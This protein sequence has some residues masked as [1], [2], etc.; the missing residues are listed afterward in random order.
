MKSIFSILCLIYASIVLGQERM[1]YND[2][3]YFQVIT[4]STRL[5]KIDSLQALLIDFGSSSTFDFE[6]TIRNNPQLKEIQLYKPTQAHIDLLSSIPLPQL[7]YLF[8]E[9]YNAPRLHIPAFPIVEHFHLESKVLQQL[10]MESAAMDSL[11]ILDVETL[12]LTEWKAAQTYFK[13]GLINLKAP[14]LSVLPFQQL[15]MLFQCSM[16]CSFNEFPT[17]LCNSKEL[18]LFSLTNYKVISVPKCLIRQLKKQGYYSDISLYDS[19]NGELVK[20][21]FSPDRKK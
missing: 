1:P 2:S 8:I 3:L 7:K 6:Y 4:E 14:Q 15:P 21:Y 20:A 13:L 11:N 10:N 16:Y 19:M 17:V 9:G 18:T 12:S 5:Q